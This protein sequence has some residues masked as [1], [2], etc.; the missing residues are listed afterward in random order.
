[1]AQIN[2]LL[3]ELDEQTIAK[4]H[5]IP[6]DTARIRYKLKS[7]T[8]K[9]FGEFEWETGN[10]YNYMFTT[11]VSRGGNLSD[12]EA[13]S[14]AKELLGQEFRRR[15]GD[16]VTAYND[17]H[18]GTNGGLRTILDVITEGLK[19]ESVERYVL[20]TFDRY[21]AP[22]SWGQKVEI[23]RQFIDHCGSHL[24]SS[25]HRDQPER[26][27]QNFQELIHS[28]VVTLQQTSSIFRRL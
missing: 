10:F 9:N 7:I 24:S 20:A 27:A 26:Y 8:V 16:I 21:V 4:K 3:Y 17:A 6:F 28:Y 22:N 1:V 23:I 14:R 2:S 18:N 12:D 11:C 25:I 13:S 15:G 19:K 5:G